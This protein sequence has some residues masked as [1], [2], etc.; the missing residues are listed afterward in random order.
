MPQGARNESEDIEFGVMLPNVNLLYLGCS[1]L[2]LSAP[3]DSC[4]RHTCCAHAFLLTSFA[5]LLLIATSTC[6]DAVDRSYMNR[7]WTQFEAYLSMRRI[8]ADGLVDVNDTTNGRAAIRLLHATPGGFRTALVQEWAF[9]TPEEAHAILAGPDVQVASL[10]HV[11]RPR[12]SHSPLRVV[13]SRSRV[14]RG[15]IRTR[16]MKETA[17][18]QRRRSPL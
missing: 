6:F 1:V 9:K 12:E 18:S 15:Q 7:F 17:L 4:S 3:R 8:S 13:L 16:G 5:R 11:A 10:L 14:Q 2:I